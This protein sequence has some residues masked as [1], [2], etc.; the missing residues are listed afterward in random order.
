MTLNKQ[1]LPSLLKNL[2][3][4]IG[5]RAIENALSSSRVDVRA[6]GLRALSF[7]EKERPSDQIQMLRKLV[8]EKPNQ[9]I[10]R[11][12]AQ[13]WLRSDLEKNS[14]LPVFEKLAKNNTA[15]LALLRA[16]RAESFQFHAFRMPPGG[17]KVTLGSPA[18]EAG[19]SKNEPIR[20][21]LLTHPFE[22]Q[23]TP[24]TQAQWTLVMGENPSN[25]KQGGEVVGGIPMNPN[26]P[27]EKVSWEDVQKFIEKLNK[28]DDHSTY[29]LPTEAEWEVAARA[30]TST[31]YSF[32]DN[33]S[34][35]SEYGWHSGNSGNQTHD[36]A[37][38]K[39]NPAGLYDV[40]GNVWEWVQ[41]RYEDTPKGG[42]DVK[43][44]TGPPRGS[45]R[46]YRGGSWNSVAQNLRS[47]E[48]D[49]DHPGNRHSGFGF[50][51]VRQ[52]RP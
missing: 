19:R 46:V 9:P 6:F 2:K 50:R 11:Q 44:P 23:A 17:K 18:A 35:L 37:S 36:V 15:T 34:D 26:R 1:Y 39:P 14:S 49:R 4:D 31:A 24:V 38:L 28:L 12:S 7:A 22:M 47:A 21:V 27:V 10:D 20:E 8:E 41:D 25:F 33:S 3:P 13:A 32:G 43:D 30:E 29:R 48:R 16:A 52:P 51:L 5:N 45:Y 42:T 40:H